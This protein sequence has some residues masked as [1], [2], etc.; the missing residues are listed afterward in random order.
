MCS[1]VILSAIFYMVG[2]RDPVETT[3]SQVVIYLFDAL[4][5]VYLLAFPAVCLV[6][7]PRLRCRLRSCRAVTASPR[8]PPDQLP[9]SSQ[10]AHLVAY[11]RADGPIEDPRNLQVCI[12]RTQTTV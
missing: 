10:S 4:V 8:S 12:E 7:H 3:G 6:Y 2:M 1:T 9:A 5:L 11:R